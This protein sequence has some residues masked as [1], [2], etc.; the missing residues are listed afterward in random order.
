MPPGINSVTPIC[1]RVSAACARV[2]P[3]TP[4]FDAQYAVASP[5]ALMP[6]VEA[7]VTTVTE[8][9]RSDGSAARTTAAVPSRLTV[10]MRSDCGPGK[11]PRPTGVS[12]PAAVTTASR[13]PT[14][15]MSCRTA[16][17]AARVSARSTT[18]CSMSATGARPSPTGRP[19]AARTA[20]ATAAPNP[21]AAP[22]TSTAPIFVGSLA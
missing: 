21:W 5:T 13:P 7:T 18:S 22:V 10:T 12:V 9:A 2:K 17:S 4:N 19:P 1:P 16:S 11:L 3:T 15:S 14:R 8:R 6:R 20:P